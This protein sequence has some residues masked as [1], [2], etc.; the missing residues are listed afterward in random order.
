MTTPLLPPFL[1]GIT[2]KHTHIPS[3]VWVGVCVCLCVCVCV[4]VCVYV[5]VDARAQIPFQ[6]HH[7]QHREVRVFD[8]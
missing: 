5:C 4:C 2:H 8:V 6:S 7:V 3:W 1:S